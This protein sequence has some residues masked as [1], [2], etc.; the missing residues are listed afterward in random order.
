MTD[1]RLV[2]R[3]DAVRRPREHARQQ[4]AGDDAGSEDAVAATRRE[5]AMRELDRALQQ[6]AAEEHA[7]ER[8]RPMARADPEHGAMDGARREPALVDVL[9]QLV[10]RL[11][12]VAGR[13]RGRGRSCW[14]GRRAAGRPSSRCRSPG[15]VSSSVRANCSVPSP[16]FTTSRSTSER[17]NSPSASGRTWALSVSTWSTS[18]WCRSPSST[19]GH[20]V[21]VASRT[22]NCSAGRL[23][24]STSSLRKL[25]ET[26]GASVLL[27][28]GRNPDARSSRCPRPRFE[29]RPSRLPT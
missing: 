13:R 29:Q 12:R 26:V 24:R 19:L 5:Q 20:L 4:R 10:E 25:G 28:G 22:Q 14:C 15:F 21:A 23:A 8:G 11:R 27:L 1:L 7:V 2:R 17:A 6:T 3:G 18:G 9:E 16:P